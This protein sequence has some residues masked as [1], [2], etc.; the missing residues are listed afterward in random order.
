MKLFLSPD[1]AIELEFTF[2]EDDGLGRYMLVGPSKALKMLTS[3]GVGTTADGRLDVAGK[4]SPVQSLSLN[5][6]YRSV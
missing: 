3:A 5:K 2:S 4:L 1:V 6:T